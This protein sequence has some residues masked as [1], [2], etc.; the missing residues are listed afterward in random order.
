M[1]RAKT[2]KRTTKKQTAPSNPVANDVSGNSNVLVSENASEPM[3]TESML[4]ALLNAESKVSVLKPWL[5]IDRGTR[6]KLLRTF[7]EKNKDYTTQEKTDLLQ[8]LVDALDRRLLNSKSQITY[9]MEKGEISEV[10]ALKVIK[11][12][13]GKTIFR[14]EPPNRGTKKARR[15]T[16]PDSD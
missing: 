9:N 4:N 11:H 8:I 15:A 10:N 14:V 5:R 12:T 1:F 16:S 3:T 13:E 2:V 7:V 6:M